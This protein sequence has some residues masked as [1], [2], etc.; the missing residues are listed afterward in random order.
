MP[1]NSDIISRLEQLDETLRGQREAFAALTGALGE[2][3][4]EHARRIALSEKAISDLKRRNGNGPGS[5]GVSPAS[6]R[7]LPIKVILGLIG[8]ITALVSLL[9]PVI[10]ALIHHAWPAAP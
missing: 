1:D 6:L 2:R 10:A 4:P 8:I 5:A 7:D 3:C 9:S